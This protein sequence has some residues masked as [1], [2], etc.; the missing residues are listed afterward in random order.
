MKKLFFALALLP[1]AACAVPTHITEEDL[2]GKTYMLKEVDGQ[3]PPTAPPAAAPPTLIFNEEQGK[4]L[5]Y[6]AVCNRFSGQAK[7]QNNVLRAPLL[8]ATK[9]FCINN[10]LNA[11]ENNLFRMLEAGAELS[12]ENDV[13][14]LRQGEHR[15]VYSLQTK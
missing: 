8:A 2:L 11:L 7:L 4:M 3:A 1:L 13:L 9:M 14:I 10:E 5:L 6:G 15:L 12:L